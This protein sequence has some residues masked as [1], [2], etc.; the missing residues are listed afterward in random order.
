MKR[1]Q[2]VYSLL[3]LEEA[4]FAVQ[5]EMF[6]HCQTQGTAALRDTVDKNWRLNA[7][8][9]PPRNSAD[10]RYL[11]SGSLAQHMNHIYR[12]R[13]YYTNYSKISLRNIDLC[14]TGRR[15]KV[16]AFPSSPQL[17]SL[18]SPPMSRAHNQQLVQDEKRYLGCRKQEA[19]N[20]STICKRRV[21]LFSI[22]R[23]PGSQLSG[24]RQRRGKCRRCL[25]YRR[26]SG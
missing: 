21:C 4:S 15:A 5:S 26:S 25:L 9:W 18:H 14:H 24:H 3:R 20:L 19:S 17:L 11:C 22:V 16:H 13:H 12:I 8:R 1:R 2:S 6:R 23:V 7:R 10:V